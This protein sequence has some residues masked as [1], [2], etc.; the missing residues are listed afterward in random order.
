MGSLT[1]MVP[2]CTAADCPAHKFI[3]KISNIS[4]CHGSQARI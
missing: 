3:E 2:E 1:S 4:L